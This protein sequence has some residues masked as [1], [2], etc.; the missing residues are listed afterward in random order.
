VK[1]N[2]VP[3]GRLDFIAVSGDDPGMAYAGGKGRLWQHLISLMPPHDTYIETHLGGGAVM[4]R[5]KP[6][7][8][9]IGVDISPEV[10]RAAA[11]WK[12][13][14]LTLLNC[15]AVRFLKEF[16]FTGSELIYADPPY[17]AA[18]KKKRRYYKYE[19]SDED[20]QQLLD[21]LLRVR[22]NVMISGYS[23]ELYE[24]RLVGWHRRE[25]R[26]VTHAG[27]R[28]EIVWANFEF[29]ATLHD[30][31]CIGDD[32]RERERIRRKASRWISNLQRMPELE[33]RAIVAAIRELHDHA[34]RSLS[35]LA[36]G[37]P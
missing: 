18:T 31:R 11:D 1:I 13:P 25:L 36:G 8:V 33:R 6:A 20:H 4:R 12:V 10:K 5:K 22:C 9:N 35:E 2:D 32:F 3:R 24:T 27:C 21:T 30:Y 14:H 29:T 23:S 17:L 34:D 15:D 7:R 16:S 26:N 37:R 28:T 19:Y